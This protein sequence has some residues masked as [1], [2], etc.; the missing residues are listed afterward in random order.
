[1]QFLA[2]TPLL[3]QSGAQI[4]N[5]VHRQSRTFDK[6]RTHL[7]CTS[8]GIPVPFT[9]IASPFMGDPSP[10]RLPAALGRPFVAKPASG[11]GGEGVVMDVASVREVQDARRTYWQERYLLQQRVFPRYLDGRRAWFRVFYVCGRVIP[12]WWDDRTHAY[13]PLTVAE[14]ARFGVA[15]LYTIMERISRA[16]ALDLFT[17]EI[18]LGCDG[19]LACIDYANS[20]CDLRLQSE[21][22]DGVPD[23]VADRIIDALLSHL[24]R[25][26][27]PLPVWQRAL[28]VEE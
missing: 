4:I 1:L 22:P 13:T 15:G 21:H 19:R 7:L 14:E 23:E 20:P 28:V 6:A 18:V 25:R 2:L 26:L 8:R 10:P 24:V 9:V 27:Q 5:H 16:V 3:E 17:T 12:C 11:G